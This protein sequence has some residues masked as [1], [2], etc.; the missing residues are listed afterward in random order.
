MGKFLIRR[1]ITLVNFTTILTVGGIGIAMALLETILETMN[2]KG[3]AI[4][5]RI[6]AIGIFS[7]FAL[8]LFNGLL[9]EMEA[10]VKEWTR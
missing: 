5:I 8:N 1:K 7:Y 2:Q 10:F 4:L 9:L 3:Y 6:V